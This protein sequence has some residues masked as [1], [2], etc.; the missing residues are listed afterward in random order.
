MVETNDIHTRGETLPAG[1]RLLGNLQ[2]FKVKLV[3]SIGQP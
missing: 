2:V 3:L 1:E